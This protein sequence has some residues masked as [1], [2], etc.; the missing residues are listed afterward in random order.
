MQFTLHG[1]LCI[2]NTVLWKKKKIARHE[3]YL[4]FYVIPLLGN[5]SYETDMDMSLADASNI[6]IPILNP[7]NNMGSDDDE[8]VTVEIENLSESNFK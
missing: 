5:L 1:Q 7:N 8:M 4:S 6:R 2:F 3:F